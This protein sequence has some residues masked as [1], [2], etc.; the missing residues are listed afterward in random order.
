MPP[1]EKQRLAALELFTV[2]NE[3]CL[4]TEKAGSYPPDEV[5]A[6]YSKVCPLLYLKGTLLPDIPRDDEHPGERYVNE[7]DWETVFE[8]IKKCLGS[9]DEFVTV[10]DEKIETQTVP[11]S[12][13]EC[14]A[15]MYQDLKDFSMAYQQPY[16]FM[17][18][19]ALADCKQLFAS[20]WGK[21]IVNLLPTIHELVYLSV[22]NQED[23]PSY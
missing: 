23:E 8:S 11:M 3:F 16:D 20:R 2:A 10:S 9:R 1:D 4:F 21:R 22:E 15:D 13:G 7:E 17:K 14:L 19:N 5:L 6:Y 12:I 18:L